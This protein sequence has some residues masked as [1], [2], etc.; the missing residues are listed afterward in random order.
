MYSTPGVRVGPC[1]GCSVG[2]GCSRVLKCSPNTSQVFDLL[3]LAH[4][5]ALLRD[6]VSRSKCNIAMAGNRGV[7]LTSASAFSDDDSNS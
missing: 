6:S 4:L 7:G 2:N 1:R 3:V 5:R